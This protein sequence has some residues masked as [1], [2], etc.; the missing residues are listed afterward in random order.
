MFQSESE[1]TASR[2]GLITYSNHNVQD[3]APVPVE[4]D[5]L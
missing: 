4:P 3:K 1:L 5:V 2:S